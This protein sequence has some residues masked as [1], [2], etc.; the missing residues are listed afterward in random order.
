MEEI[1]N[2]LA[3]NFKSAI[4][5]I[6]ANAREKQAII[7]AQNEFLNIDREIRETQVGKVQRD[8]VIKKESG[9]KTVKAV[10]I[11]IPIQN[12]IVTTATAFEVGEAPT[13]TANE[14]NKLSEEVDRLWKQNRI[15]SILQKLV[16]MQKSQLQAAILFYIEDLKPDNLI[17]RILGINSNKDIK[18][19]ILDNKKGEM[20]PYFDAFGDMKLFL[21]EFTTKD[22][23]KDINNA[24]IYD[25]KF[26]YK[27]SDKEPVTNKAVHG[28]SKIPVV[29]IE[30]QNPEWFIA[31]A[32]IDRLE[33]SL[34]KLGASNDYSAYPILKL[35]GEV[36]GLPDKDDDGKALRL[37]QKVT[38][39]GKTVSADAEFL[40]QSNATD[41]IKLELEKLE[42]FI[43]SLTSTPDIS[44]ES[45]K[46]LGSIS[47]IAIKLMFMDAILKA[48]MNEG[49]NRTMIERII[50]V[51]ISGIITTTGTGLKSIASKTVF[52]VQFNS[53]LPDD[54]KETVSV[55]SEGKT[56]GLISQKTGVKILGLTEDD[57]QE[58]EDINQYSQP[59]TGNA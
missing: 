35:Y 5:K 43:Y 11:P 7:D 17:N 53:I 3:T 52:S 21:W 33:V 26:V 56:S 22:G 24:W 19:K 46:G 31:Q 32:M 1:L 41:S 23:D 29:Y 54:L 2:L 25:E 28:F 58:I 14:S 9:S 45:V 55:L 47:G 49:D 18:N 16:K 38:E 10:R 37:E 30:Q 40:T 13:I 6:K 48:K 39:D 36:N 15:D 27:W 34:S 59:N 42:K 20:T 44:F 57:D 50:N 51:Y 8:K 4:E 12:K